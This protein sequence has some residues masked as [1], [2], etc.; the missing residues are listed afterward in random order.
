MGRIVRFGPEPARGRTRARVGVADAQ[1]NEG[2]EAEAHEGEEAEGGGDASQGNDN[3][4]ERVAKYIP[5]EVIA[6]FIFVNSIL[7]EDAG[8]A[9]AG[10]PDPADATTL[11]QALDAA[12]LG[13]V[14][15]W[16]V[17][18]LVMLICL[19][20]IPL[21]LLA[22]R[23]K[24]DPDE[25][26]WL[27]IVVALAAFPVWAYAIDAV[28]FRPWHNGVLASIALATFSFISGAIAPSTLASIRGWFKR[29]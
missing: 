8:R 9:T 4:A 5:A 12:T 3:Y 15:V 14:S 20:M 18:W 2:E 16:T 29:G 27:N 26:P 1:A 17:S 13:W 22:M 28:A 23:D 7:R 11:Q 19:A 24:D 10:V 25:W 6:F 21:Y